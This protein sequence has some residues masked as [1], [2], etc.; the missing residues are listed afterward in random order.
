MLKRPEWKKLHKYS[1]SLG[2]H[3]VLN[4]VTS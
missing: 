2:A 4:E 1:A 3:N